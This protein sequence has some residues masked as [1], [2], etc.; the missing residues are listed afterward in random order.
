MDLSFWQKQLDALIAAPLPCL[1]F[2][3]LGLIAAWWFR[4]SVMRG[5]VNALRERNTVLEER[6]RLAAEQS[7]HSKEEAEKLRVELEKLRGRITSKASRH[8]L[9]ESV[10]A[11]S[12]FISGLINRERQ[13]GETLRADLPIVR[14]RY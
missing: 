2:L 12:T 8:E 9:E 14:P 4:G 10:S 3:A 7:Q 5:E 6:Q 11:A 13:V 1:M